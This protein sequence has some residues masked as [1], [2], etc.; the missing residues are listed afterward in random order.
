MK[1]PAA[2]F[3]KAE[4]PT[5]A[6]RLLRDEWSGADDPDTLRRMK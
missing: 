6:A 3:D 2:S 5:V 4:K 1:P